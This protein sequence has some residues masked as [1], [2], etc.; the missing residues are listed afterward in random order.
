MS[1][2]KSLVPPSKLR[3]HRNVLT[4]SERIAKMQEDEQWEEGRTVYGLPKI[5]NIMVRAKKKV[6]K[7]EEE[8]AAEGAVAPAAEGAAEPKKEEKKDK[9]DKKDKK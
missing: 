9:K 3:R 1:I 5:R 8:V 7:V 6:K 4:R 2:D